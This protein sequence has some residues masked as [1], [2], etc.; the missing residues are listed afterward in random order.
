MEDIIH[1]LSEFHKPD[2][3]N[4]KEVTSAEYYYD[5]YSH[6]TMHEQIVNDIETVETYRGWIEDNQ[7]I[8]KVISFN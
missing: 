6:I 2:L 1:R 4:V 3:D 5:P 7:H 8:I